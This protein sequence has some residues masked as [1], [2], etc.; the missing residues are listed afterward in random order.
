[1]RGQDTTVEFYI[2]NFP[3]IFDP[4]AKVGTYFSF[5]HYRPL[6]PPSLLPVLPSPLS[7]K[8]FSAAWKKPRN[9]SFVSPNVKIDIWCENV[10]I[11]LLFYLFKATNILLFIYALI[12]R[13]NGDW[14]ISWL[15]DWFIDWLI[16]RLFWDPTR[17]LLNRSLSRTQ[18]RNISR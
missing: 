12:T 18:S 5:H 7:S 11:P 6:P 1:M 16:R 9:C 3:F 13:S 14:F 2:C 4:I 15:Y 8:I 17:S 10:L